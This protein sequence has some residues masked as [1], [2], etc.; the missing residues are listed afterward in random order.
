VTAADHVWRQIAGLLADAATSVTMVAPF[1]KKTIF[2]DAL[3]QVPAS[4]G[5]IDCVTRWSPAE[6]AAGVSDPEIIETAR[7]DQRVR[8]RLCPALHAKLYLAD[9][10]CLVGSAN[11]TAT[12]TG[13]VAEVN[14]ELLIE[15]VSSHAEVRRLLEQIES[16]AVDATPEMAA[17]IR[18]QADLLEA[19][20]DNRPPGELV[21]RWYP[22]T[23]RPEL[24]FALYSGRSASLTSAV[25]NGIMRDLAMLD[26]PAG[27]SESDFTITVGNR[28]QALPELRQL[29]DSKRLSN[30]ELQR[31]IEARVGLPPDQARRI[32]ETLAAW[33]QHFASY[34]T[35]IGSWEL[36][37]GREHA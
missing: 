36:R 3:A 28:L 34:Y 14:V 29:I 5:K 30:I 6:V 27:L 31:A 13:R 21:P 37:H 16:S 32:T 17:L 25:R 23:R 8:L 10:R 15:T 11:L 7:A 20:R 4:V 9:A 33:L 24:L 35:E 22:E 1:I 2:D 18:Q 26:V 12:A 19:A